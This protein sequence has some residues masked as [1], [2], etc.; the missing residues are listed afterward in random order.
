MPATNNTLPDWQRAFGGPVFQG[1][2]KQNP[3]DF[4][5]TEVLGFT[6]ASTQQLAHVGDGDNLAA[7]LNQP[8]Y[9]CG[10]CDHLVERQVGGDAAARCVD[11]GELLC[12]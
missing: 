4:Q 5:V 2:I 3:S 1:L 6:Q 9:V 8:L 11:D 10:Q 12:L 7:I